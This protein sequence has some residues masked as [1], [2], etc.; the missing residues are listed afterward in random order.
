MKAQRAALNQME[1]CKVNL[2]ALVLITIQNVKLDG[3]LSLIPLYT[4][5][6]KYIMI[7][8]TNK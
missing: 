8:N 3:T 4:N 1:C 5:K 2:K 6:L 7:D